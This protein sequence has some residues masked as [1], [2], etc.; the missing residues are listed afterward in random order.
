MP[1][2]VTAARNAKPREKTYRL[3]DG[4]GMYLEVTPKG[5]RYWRLKYRFAGKEK[6]FA[7]GVFP[8]VSLKEA[9]ERR[10]RARKLLRDGIDPSFHKQAVKAA[11]M[12]QAINSFEVIAME[13]FKRQQAVWTS[14]H[15]RTVLLR[16]KNNVF[17]WIGARPI[18]EITAKEL[19]T[20]L[21]RVEDRGALET[22]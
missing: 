12:E 7:I 8:E 16:L 6:R 3:T 13:W 15:S 18:A 20:V 9:R 11:H 14:G 5:G 19:L 21:R 10:D 1:L 2:T 22:A 4:A 17:P